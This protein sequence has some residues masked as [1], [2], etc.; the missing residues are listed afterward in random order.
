MIAATAATM[1]KIAR[2]PTVS[3][4]TPEREGPMVGAKPMTRPMIP[5]A[6]PRRSRG[7]TSRMTLNTMG[8]TKPVAQACITRPKSSSGNTGAT[9]ETRLPAAKSVMPPMKSLRVEKRPMRYAASGM[10]T[11]S[12]RA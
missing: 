9:A 2:Q 11:A 10:M 12:V 3:T 8:I 4:N 7:M 6:L 5:M 1:T